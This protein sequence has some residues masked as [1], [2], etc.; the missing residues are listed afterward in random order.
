MFVLINMRRLLLLCVVRALWHGFSGSQNAMIGGVG[1]Q[2]GVVAFGSHEVIVA[3]RRGLT[4]GP[5]GYL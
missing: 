2:L 5:R 4:P 1:N 3:K